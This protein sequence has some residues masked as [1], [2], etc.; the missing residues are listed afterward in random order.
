M[1][2]G[3]LQITPPRAGEVTMSD[4]KK[5]LI[6]SWRH[7]DHLDAPYGRLLSVAHA[8]REEAENV[9]RSWIPHYSPVGLVEEVVTL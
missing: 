6:I 1:A 7:V 2:K 3:I 5:W 9:A 4:K 8:T